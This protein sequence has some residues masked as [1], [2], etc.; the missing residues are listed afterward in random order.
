MYFAAVCMLNAINMWFK[1]CSPVRRQAASA[2]VLN[3]FSLVCCAFANAHAVLESFQES[4]LLTRRSVSRANVASPISDILI[5][6]N[7]HAVLTRLSELN[8]LTRPD[9]PS[10]NVV[11]SFVS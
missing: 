10:A 11:D 3:S 8:L 4:N 5:V 1:T 2:R 6:V 7:A 9:V